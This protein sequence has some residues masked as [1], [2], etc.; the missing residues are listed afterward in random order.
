MP[1]PKLN[2]AM[3]GYQFMGRAHSNAWRQVARFFE[4]APYEPVLKVVCGRNALAVE[5]AAQQLG[6]EEHATSWEEVVARDD[7]ITGLP[8]CGAAGL[9]CGPTSQLGK[10]GNS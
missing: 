3:I 10:V 5:K 2:V 7:E 6:F 4:D 1:K 8:H 9:R